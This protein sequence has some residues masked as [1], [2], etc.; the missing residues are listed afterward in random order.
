MPGSLIKL[1][2]F[3]TNS[4]YSSSSSSKDSVAVSSG[5]EGRPVLEGKL[6]FAKFET[7]KINDCIDFIRSKQLRLSGMFL[8]FSSNL[9]MFAPGINFYCLRLF[10]LVLF[11]QVMRLES[12][13]EISIFYWF[14][15]F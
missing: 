11:N 4:D 9:G 1:V 7:A 6:H 8:S 15:S 14:T 10:E 2:Y 3:S 12:W 5:N 13:I